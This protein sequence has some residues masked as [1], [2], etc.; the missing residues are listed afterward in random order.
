[1]RQSLHIFRKDV[2]YLWREICPGLGAGGRVRADQTS[3]DGPGVLAAAI[4]LMARLIHAE[5]IP[6]DRQFWITRPYRWQSLFG[7]KLL[8]MLAFVNLPLML[9]QWW[10]A[11]AAG[12]P[13]SAYLPGLLWSQVVMILAVSLP[14]VAL[15]SVTPGIV[16]FI[17]SILIL[18]AVWYGIVTLST[19]RDDMPSALQVWPGAIGWIRATY[20][21]LALAATALSMLY[22]QYRR[23]MTLL[24]RCYW[25]GRPRQ[26][27]RGP[28]GLPW[29]PA[30]AWK[31]GFPG[32]R[33]RRRFCRSRLTRQQRAILS[34]A[35]R[36]LAQ[37]RRAHAHRQSRACPLVSN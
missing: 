3:L 1:M 35:I 17:F 27:S 23:R 10:I 4:Y 26:F 18:A 28:V 9:A 37:H 15:A 6:G 32:S 11:A 2:R 14:A 19:L 7:A 13:A 20:I 34:P 31:S 36:Y 33:S 8:F 25:R 21:V 12:F 30:W 22:G 24:S 29:A 5:A 16:S